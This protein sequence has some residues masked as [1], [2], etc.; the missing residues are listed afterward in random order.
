VNNEQGRPAGEAY[1]TITQQSS[2]EA[3]LGKH[4]ETFPGSSRWV[5]V[6]K[7]DAQKK[8]SHRASYG[9]TKFDGV[10][11]LRGLPFSSTID[12]LKQF[13]QGLNMVEESI[14]FPTDRGTGSTGEAFVQFENYASA[15]AGLAKNREYIQGRYI[16]V[17]K[18]SNNDMRKAMIQHM[19]EHGPQ[20]VGAGFQE[21]QVP[22]NWG[23]LNLGGGGGGPMRGGNRNN[24]GG[25]QG[26]Y[27]R[28]DNSG[29]GNNNNN[30]G[31]NFGGPPSGF[32]QN[33]W[34]N[35]NQNQNQ[36]GGNSGGNQS[37]GPPPQ[38][39]GF[40]APPTQNAAPPQQAPQDPNN[41][42]PHCIG[43]SGIPQGTQN[44]QI[45]E[46]FLPNKAIAV[47]LSAGNGNGDVAFNSHQ[48]ACNAMSKHGTMMNGATLSLTLKSQ[49]PPPPK[50]E[51]G[52]TMF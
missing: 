25:N 15:E 5:E 32:A 52:F 37:G 51:S 45:Q 28:P 27:S 6:R 22:Q 10:V 14:F 8:S 39:N 1:V 46:F 16:E 38:S 3:A 36:W 2:A 18:S 41:P 42:F 30:S 49:G 26:P 24:S 31:G 23:G 40:G 44:K 12:D 43:V 50:V 20:N 13:F 34:G 35:Q 4:K 7:S 9:A 47:N 33:N 29:W 48:D 19:K 11:R 17:F 21:K